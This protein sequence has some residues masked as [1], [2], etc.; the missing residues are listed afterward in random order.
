MDDT[1][2]RKILQVAHDC[3]VGAG[4]PGACGSMALAHLQGHLGRPVENEEEE[5]FR[6]AWNL[7]V[8]QI[9]GVKAAPDGV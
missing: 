3:T 1:V 5:L 6:S 9:T 2:R 4:Y 7:C 8:S